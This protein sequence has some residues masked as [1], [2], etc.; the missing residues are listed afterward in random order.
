MSIYNLGKLIDPAEFDVYIS[1]AEKLETVVHRYGS[2]FAV[3]DYPCWMQYKRER[4]VEGSI[5]FTRN[6]YK[7]PILNQMTEKVVDLLTP[8]FPEDMK[9]IRERVHFIKTLGSITPHRDEAGRM[10]CINIGIKDSS[11]ALTQIGIDDLFETFEERHKDYVVRE[12]YAY[13]L[14]THVMHAVVG[15][16]IPRYLITY[17][18]GETY[19]N[20]LSRLRLT[21]IL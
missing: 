12:G 9:P 1:E 17:G 11:S 4:G 13:L 2:P 14:N 20:I 3:P 7:H 16:N 21:S 5:S 19:D 15:T 10:S 8:I 6:T 18:F